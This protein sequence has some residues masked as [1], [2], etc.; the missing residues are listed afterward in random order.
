[1]MRVMPLR[2]SF[3][4]NLSSEILGLPRA[5]GISICKAYGVAD[6]PSY[7][8]H[9]DGHRAKAIQ[10]SAICTCCRRGPKQSSAA[11]FTPRQFLAFV[12][13]RVRRVPTLF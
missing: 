4:E 12:N 13:N 5:N 1:M 6:D 10:I 7:N 9:S 3:S 11:V 8:Y 2:K